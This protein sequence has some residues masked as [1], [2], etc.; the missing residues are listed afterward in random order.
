MYPI[1]SLPLSL[2]QEKVNQWVHMHSIKNKIKAN[3]IYQMTTLS[4]N[5]SRF[6][7]KI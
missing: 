6:F 4:Q 2:M 1:Q 7:L 5:S 3:S